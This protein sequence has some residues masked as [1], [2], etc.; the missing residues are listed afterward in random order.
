MITPLQHGEIA[1]ELTGIWNI[2]DPSDPVLESTLPFDPLEASFLGSSSALLISPQ[3]GPAQLWDLTDPRHPVR[4]A[5][6]GSVSE[7][8]HTTATN[9]VSTSNDGTL[10][11]VFSSDGNDWLWRISRGWRATRL[12]SIPVPHDSTAIPEL[13]PDGR[14]ALVLTKQGIQWWDVTNPARP[15]RADFSAMP[16]VSTGSIVGTNSVLAAAWQPDRRSA[17]TCNDLEFFEVSD[18]H[19]TASARVPGT[20]GDQLGISNDGRVLA[21][22]GPGDNGLTLRTVATP[23]QPVFDALLKTLPELT[24][25]AISADDTRLA[26]WDFGT[27]QLW[28]IANPADPALLASLNL[29]T[30]PDDTGITSDIN[31]ATFSPF[32][33][34]LAVG[35]DSRVVLVDKDPA[36][37]ARQYCAETSSPVT[38]AQWPGYAS[39]VPVQDPCPSG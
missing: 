5:T 2:S 39:N 24:G 30:Q 13:M 14:T 20:T 37:V 3:V 4:T 7:S 18:G 9:G 8:S 31:N 12:G 16:Y 15:R 27:L 38:S 33:P 29:S 35:V 26:D 17:C 28:N 11:S 36:A 34:E 10:V 1:S 32:G 23:G 19:V 6:L 21:A 25:I 22:A